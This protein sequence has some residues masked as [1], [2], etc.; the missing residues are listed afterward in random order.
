[1]YRQGVRNRDPSL[2]LYGETTLSETWQVIWSCT[3]DTL[4]HTWKHIHHCSM[5]SDT[6]SAVPKMVNPTDVKVGNFSWK[7]ETD[8]SRCFVHQKYPHTPVE[9]NVSACD[10][11]TW[12][13]T[14][15]YTAWSNTTAH[16]P[17]PPTIGPW[18][19][20]YLTCMWSNLL[21]FFSH[22][23]WIGQHHGVI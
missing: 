22:D 12:G 10:K 18:H 16:S 19:P 2:V 3:T 9:A 7:A 15:W 1:M 23:G 4:Q 17:S 8:A 13:H 5:P 11:L 14:L 21:M 20:F 6:T